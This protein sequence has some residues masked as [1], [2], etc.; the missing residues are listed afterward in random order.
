MAS[1]KLRH[2]TWWAKLRIPQELRSEYGGKA[3]LEVSLKTGDAR[4]ARELAAIWEG[5]MREEFR[6]K[7]GR[8]N[9]QET[10]LRRLYERLREDAAGGAFHVEVI[11]RDPD[12]NYYREDPIVAGID[13]KLEEI[14]ETAAQRELTPA[15]AAQLAA[16]QD[17]QRAQQGRPV[18]RR[19]EFEPGFWEVSQEYMKAWKRDKAGNR[20][21]NTEQQKLATFAL[22]KGFWNDQPL[23]S[24]ATKD[25]AAF[26]DTLKGF[27]PNWARSPAAKKMSWQ[28]LL[29]AFGGSGKRLSD[30]TMNRHMATLQSLWEWA[31]KRGHC[32]GDNPFEGFHR[33]LKQGV[34][35]SGYVAWEIDELKKLLTP[36]PKRQDLLEVILVGMFSGMRLDEIAS[37]KWGQLRKVGKEEEA[38]HFFQVEDAKTPAGNRQVP[39]HSSLK[40]LVE[41]TRGADGDRIWPQFNPEGPGKKPGADAGRDF[42]R[43]KASRGFETRQKTF[44]SFRK[45]VTRIMERAGVAENEWAQVFGHERGFTFR[46]YNPDG[47]TIEQKAGIIERIAYPG[48]DLP[49]PAQP[50]ALKKAA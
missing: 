22:F 6:E 40:W 18:K 13:F 45:N 7:A 24:V 20:E 16:L 39:V 44:H 19:A 41:R 48:L 33:K 47:I 21:T 49:V 46:V 8:A 17:A 5:R 11:E 31:R 50:K 29:K 9:S 3:Q 4:Q 1:I 10:S 32:E 2:R 38:I 36:A 14:A 12:G 27:D 43:F 28:E 42:S 26:R 34:N 35:V 15:E 30:A 23:R 25:A 37:L